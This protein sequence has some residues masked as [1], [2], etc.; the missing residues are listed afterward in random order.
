M[1]R[2]TLLCFCIL[3]IASP[4]AAQHG[5][6]RLWYDKPAASWNEAMPIGNGR[7]AAM[8][9]G[10]PAH[11][12]LQINEESVWAGGPN[13]NVKPDAYPFIQQARQ[14][15]DHGKYIEAQQLADSC[16]QPYG[17]SGMA[18]QPV[19]DLHITFPGHE[20]VEFYERDLDLRRAVTSVSY[21][22]GRVKFRRQAIASLADGVI[23]LHLT[24]DRPKQISCSL[25]LRS[26]EKSTCSVAGDTAILSG[27]SGDMENQKG[28]VRFVARA[29]LH[30]T[31]GTI[32]TSDSAVTL[33]GADSATIVLA[34]RTNFR[35]YNDLTGDPEALVSAD[36]HK[37]LGHSYTD[38]FRS[39]VGLYRKLFDR[40]SL[41]LGESNAAVLPTN[42]R[43]KGFARS[44]DP[45]LVALYFQFGRYLLIASSYPGSQ[46]ATLQGKWNPLMSPPWDS[47]YTININTEMN[48]WPAEVT[49]LAECHEPLFGM[50]QDLSE[51]GTQSASTIYHARGWMAHHNTDLWRITGQVD[52]PFWGLWPSGGAWLSRD[53]W[54][55]FQFCCDTVALAKQYPILRSAS[56]FFVDVLQ[57]EPTDRWLVVS[58]SISPENSY[59][60]GRQVSIT[61]GCTMDNQIVRELFSNT[62]AA[63]AVLGVDAQFADTLARMRDRLPPMMVGKHGQLQEWLHDWDDPSDRHR[64]VSHLFGLYPAGLI[65]QRS[66][67]GLFAAAK[68]SLIQR[69][70][71]ST[72]WSMGWKVN[73]WA[74]L[75]DGD[76]AYKLI[77]DQLTL[78]D[79]SSDPRRGGTYAN[80]FDA[81]PPFQ[82]DGNFGCTSG[83]AEMLIQSH[84]GAIELLPALP[85]EW[86]RGSVSGLRARGGYEI[87]IAW[88]D[89]RVQKVVVRATQSGTCRLRTSQLLHLTGKGTL[90]RSEDGSE[91][92][93]N[94]TSGSTTTL[95]AAK[96]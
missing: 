77:R 11:E 9:W 27:I 24:A 67:P 85:S 22:V 34:V 47:K 53:I 71:V 41:D 90:S 57:E 17:N 79:E 16:L 68:T 20:T 19:G 81:H 92:T 23:Y 15:L 84:D 65:T 43:V 69:G 42:E 51:T 88:D 33:V 5:A 21:Q 29:V 64:H 4:S 3:L 37:A 60:R 39:H 44:Y 35:R 32:A 86:R 52:P 2:V 94:A 63:A 7:L 72:G 10:N 38:A 31:G 82:I 49:N 14:L 28:S 80:L 6:L 36:L 70:D 45:Q 13:N 66:T 95:V 76:H 93:F 26:P 48:Y 56:L 96:K 89:G 50:L 73:L 78:V 25:W 54:E 58:P 91:Y 18:F 12:L 62:I 74:R 30:A 61:A 46:P 87:D 8:V 1:N 59:I 83:I 55:H 75:K 40:V